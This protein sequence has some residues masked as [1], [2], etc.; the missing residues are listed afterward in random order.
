MESEQGQDGWD[1][2]TNTFSSTDY[3][4]KTWGDEESAHLEEMTEEERL[5]Q[6]DSYLEE[7]QRRAQRAEELR[8]SGGY[9]GRV[10]CTVKT[11]LNST[12][13]TG[14]HSAGKLTKT[15]VDGKEDS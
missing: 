11:T 9:P 6:A 13:G 5:A 1:D 14:T 2:A 10:L 7:V 15:E 4:M 12:G 3:S 8:N